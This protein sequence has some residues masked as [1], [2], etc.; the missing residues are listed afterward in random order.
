MYIHTHLKETNQN[1]FIYNILYN[2]HNKCKGQKKNNGASVFLSPFIYV[3]SFC[4]D[5]VSLLAAALSLS[6]SLSLS[7]RSNKH[8]SAFMHILLHA[9]FVIELATSW[10]EFFKEKGVNAACESPATQTQDIVR[11]HV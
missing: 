8:L 11:Y 9:P 4:L 7:V 2:L 1:I 3:P 6:L 5:A 10:I